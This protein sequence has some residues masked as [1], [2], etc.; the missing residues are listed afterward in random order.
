MVISEVLFRDGSSVTHVT[1]ILFNGISHPH[2]ATRGT[3]RMQTE[4]LFSAK[5]QLC[6]WF[7]RVTALSVSFMWSMSAHFIIDNFGAITYYIM[8]DSASVVAMAVFHDSN[9]YNV[10]LWGW[11]DDGKQFVWWEF[12]YI[13]SMCTLW[14]L[15]NTKCFDILTRAI[16]SPNMHW[17]ANKLHSVIIQIHLFIHQRLSLS[18]HNTYPT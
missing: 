6:L 12:I 1:H 16:S 10:T 18:L 4:A 17:G 9:R 8:A 2:N 15:V 11:F 14:R 13:K 7:E 5:I 3:Y